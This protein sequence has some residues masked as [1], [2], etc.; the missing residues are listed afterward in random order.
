M[1]RIDV[2]TWKS[3]RIGDLFKLEKCKCGCASDLTDGEETLYIGAKKS[4]NGFMK[5]VMIDDSLMTDGNCIVFICDGEGSV[6]YTI[7]MDRDFI[8]STTL[9]AGYNDYLNEYIGL[10]LVTVFDLEKIRYSYGRKYAPTLC[11]TFVKLPSDENGNPDWDFM[12]KYSKS[13]WNNSL[14]TK[15]KIKNAEISADN[16]EYFKFKDIFDIRKGFYNKK[17]E[18][19]CNGNIPFLGASCTNNGVTEYYSLEE[20]ETSSKTGDEKNAPLVDKIFPKNAVCVTNN[21]SVGFAYF[22]DKEFTCSHDV[23]PLYLKDG[24]FNKY[25][26]LFIASVIMKDRYRWCYG[27]KWRPERMANSIIKLPVTKNG[28]PDWSYMENYIKKLP[29]S[30]LL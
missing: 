27:R 9:M 8:G 16:W 18:H 15:N 24:E 11:N 3:F 6:G 7:Y 21:G 14:E 13:L 20:I 12:E 23:N 17:P 1:M 25:T 19:T 5:K 30:D 10:F 26:G 2:S 29:Y 22:Q 28:K 4:H